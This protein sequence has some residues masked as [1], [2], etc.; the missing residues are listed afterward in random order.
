LAA[1][2]IATDAVWA[3]DP[4]LPP[5]GNFNLTHWYLGLP[6]DSSGGTTGD[7][8][9]I[10][11][12]EL[13]AGYSNALHFYT[14]ADGAM[15]FWAPVNGATTSG[16]SYPRS[17]LREQ[18]SPPSN[19]I[20][21]PG[22]GTHALDAQ[23]RVQQVPSTGKVII[24]QI[25][26]K[27]G[28]ARPLVKLQF[29]TGVVEAL[30]KNSPTADPDTKFYFQNVGLSNLISY[31]IQMVD[32]LVTV[33]VNGSNHTMNVFQS[34]PDWANQQFYFKAGSY[35]QDNSGTA[36]EGAR[37]A[38][39]AMAASHTATNDPPAS[40]PYR[41]V[42]T[43]HAPSSY[44]HLDNTLTEAMAGV[45]TLRT[46][47]STGGFTTDALGQAASAFSFAGSADSLWITNDLISGGGS[48]A[49]PG[50]AATGTISLQFRMLSGT[51]NT[52]Q[53]YLLAA[54][55]SSANRNQ[56][57]LF[58]EN[59]T[60]GTDPNA[61]RLRVG[62][63]TTTV[64]QPQAL[65][66]GAWHYFAMTWNEARDSDEVHWYLGAAG[67]SLTSGM[68]NPANDSVVG[69]NGPLWVGNRDTWTAGF[70]NPGSGAVDELAFWNVELSPAQI[71]QQFAAM[72]VAPAPRPVLS[73]TQAGTQ[74]ILSWPT[75]ASG[76]TLE[77][78]PSLSAPAW[79]AAGTPTVVADRYQV[80]NSLVGV[81]KFYR[82][83]KP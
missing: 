50:A 74:I 44:F 55:A 28:E 63:T 54:P 56:L 33:A 45:L 25:H 51:N 59:N 19:D 41:D 36:A 9:S 73:I 14:G 10:S 49:N 40:D 81:A 68:F 64:A 23:C 31:R 11:A 70:Q 72:L 82:L 42:V 48:G 57:G 38:F 15:T 65:V 12:A 58:V 69:D 83:R 60:A 26:S 77:A 17:E 7:S 52:G 35:C 71:Q 5:G 39:Y 37:V 29:N 53:R 47:G 75:N 67:G 66:P 34:D 24:G 79:T 8:A 2:L 20:N 18:I 78:T 43:S 76:F 27:T 4:A 46:N 22:Y 21:W 30:I 1:C 80:T 32:G 6:V 62:N 61:L 16:S 3:L 13:V